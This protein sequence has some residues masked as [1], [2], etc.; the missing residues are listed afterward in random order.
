M[1]FKEFTIQAFPDVFFYNHCQKEGA[2]AKDIRG[3][4]NAGSDYSAGYQHIMTALQGLFFNLKSIS[5][6]FHMPLYNIHCSL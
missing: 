6:L 1:Q 3:K 4:R 2:E 5:S